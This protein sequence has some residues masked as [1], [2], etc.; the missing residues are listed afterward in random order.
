MSSN[1]KTERNDQKLEESISKVMGVS[2]ETFS[3]LLHSVPLKNNET[4][5]LEVELSDLTEFLAE[6]MCS[7]MNSYSL[8]EFD[9]DK[10]EQYLKE[11][12]KWLVEARCWVVATGK[13][14]IHP[15][16]VEVPAFFGPVLASIGWVDRADINLRIVPV[17]S[18]NGFVTKDAQGN[19]QK[20]NF[21]K[22]MDRFD[23][24]KLKV[25]RD[26]FNQF[27]IQRT[28]GLP[29]D[30]KSKDDMLYRMMLADDIL[31][32]PTN[33]VPSVE[34]VFVRLLLKF[35][36][37]SEIF[38]AARVQYGIASAFKGAMTDFAWSFVIG[39]RVRSS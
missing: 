20:I 23:E 27:G 37:L 17:P 10:V 3:T 32:G 12:L 25:I 30:L 28:Y 11:Y 15:K 29:V 18:N 9:Q 26:A 35:S 8:K 24:E 5:Y 34:R 31:C 19:I 6:E 22:P 7:A 36:Y 2:K 21:H 39:P 13:L 33:Q 4:I 1:Q 38:G 16:H 14:K